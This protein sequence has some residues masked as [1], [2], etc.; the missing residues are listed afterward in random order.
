METHSL[1]SAPAESQNCSHASPNGE[2]AEAE[3]SEAELDALI[4]SGAL[5]DEILRAGVDIIPTTD[6]ELHAYIHAYYGIRIARTAVCPGHVSPFQAVADTFFIRYPDEDSV[7][8]GGRGVGK[9]LNFAITEHL[10]LRF[11]GDTIANIGAVEEQAKK[12]YS[13][14]EGFTRNPYFADDLLKKPMLSKT[15]FRNG[16]FIEVLPGTKNRVNSPHPRLACWDE[17]DLIDWAV[18]QE[19]LSM[20]SRHNG[21]PPQ[22][23]F[24]SSLKKPYGPMIRLMEGAAARKLRTY[25]FCV[26]EVIERCEPDRHQNGEG[27]KTCPLAPECLDSEVLEDGTISLLPGPGKAAR[28]DGFM[29]IDDVIKKYRALDADTWD[30]QWR[31]KRPSVKGLIFPMYDENVHVVDYEWNPALPVYCGIDFGYSNPS[32][33]IYAQV[34]ATDEVILFAED[35][36]AMRTTQELGVSMKRAPWFHSTLWRE[37]DPAAADA[38]ATLQRMGIAVHPANNTVDPNDSD[39]GIARIRWALKPN[40]RKWPLLYVARVC[41]NFRREIR[42]YHRPDTKEDRNEDERPVKVDDHAIDATRYLM[43]RLVKFKGK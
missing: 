35:Y 38:R 34:L 12:C 7:W 43:A 33:A 5:D 37:G 25:T 40:G 29:P 6:D 41:E 1:L 15:Y 16:G 19:G 22:T 39:G 20:P 10:L 32:C 28:A 27:C 23:I 30:S 3:L 2:P 31:C 24:T 8:I 36:G 11:F 4:D 17:V 13:Y 42:F 26:F 9:T 21:R 14:I 18:L